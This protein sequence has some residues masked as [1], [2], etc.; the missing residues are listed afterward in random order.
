MQRFD[1]LVHL[2]SYFHLTKL[3]FLNPVKLM[4]MNDFLLLETSHLFF[5]VEL[6]DGLLTFLYLYLILVH[7]LKLY[8]LNILLKVL[9]T[10]SNCRTLV[11]SLYLHLLNS[12]LILPNLLPQLRNFLFFPFHL[13]STSLL[14][15]HNLFLKHLSLN[16]NSVYLNLHPILLLNQSIQ[17]SFL[18]IL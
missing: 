18:L 16:I 1:F 14:N 11:N 13:L 17:H 3:Q 8:K 15:L 2:F 5:L 6:R 9:S 12:H 7:N 10:S 4:L